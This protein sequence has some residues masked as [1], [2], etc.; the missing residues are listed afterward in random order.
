[1]K[2]RA[3]SDDGSSRNLPSD[4]ARWSDGVIPPGSPPIGSGGDRD[5]DAFEADDEGHARDRDRDAQ[6]DPDRHTAATFRILFQRARQATEPSPEAV[7]RVGR[8]L[9]R[10][11]RA[12]T[13]RGLMAWR[14]VVAVVLVMVFAGAVGAALYHWGRSAVRA[15][16][17]LAG[18]RD[19]DGMSPGDASR[20]RAR[21]RV[22]AGTALPAP[23]GEAP[24]SSNLSPAGI[25][26]GP[27]SA[28]PAGPLPATDPLPAADPLPATSPRGPAGGGRQPSGAEVTI[29]SSHPRNEASMLGE[30]F[31]QLRSGGDARSALR[32]LDDYDRRY[33]SGQLR[34][35]ARVARAEAL[36]ALDRRS[37]ALPV[38]EGLQDDDKDDDHGGGVLTRHVRLTRAE[39]L[40]DA[41]RCQTALHD[42]DLVIAA[43]AGD[44]VG[45]RALYFR[46]ACRLRAG[47][48]DP[49]RDDLTR[50]LS[51]H[52]GGELSD[53]ARRAIES[54]P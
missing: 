38:L 26:D 12:S 23:T 33:P 52:P 5:G 17:G 36:I 44:A 22:T 10:T 1:M 49:A 2:S 19:E 40:V 20:R 51:L 24:P 43:G 27:P 30:A 45:G 9:G 48:L 25:P 13:V 35:E 14:L 4:P 15:T 28:A 6:R 16:E 8:L 3:S 18:H 41:G 54:L 11:S 31:R 7:A 50:Y 47:A 32:R 29:G 46:A 39:L 53:S 42:L 37:E 21:R 34:G